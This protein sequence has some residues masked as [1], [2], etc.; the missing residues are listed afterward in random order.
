MPVGSMARVSKRE[1]IGVDH[2]YDRLDD[3]FTTTNEAT[4]GDVDSHQGRTAW[5]RVEI[6]DELCRIHADTTRDGVAELR[7]LVREADRTLEWHVV[8]NDRGNINKIA[9][10]PSKVIIPGVYAYLGRTLDRMHRLI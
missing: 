2:L 9:F 5:I 6:G 8:A 1:P 7:R 10:G 3:W 4:I